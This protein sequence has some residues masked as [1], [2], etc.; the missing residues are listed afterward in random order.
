MGIIKTERLELRPLESKHAA[1]LFPIWSDEEVVKTTYIHS[2]NTIDDCINRIERVLKNSLSR[3]D[4]GPYA[5]FLENELIGIV[6]ASRDSYHEFGLA[7]HIAK[8][9]WGKGF[10]TEAAKAVVDLAFKIPEIVRISADALTTNEASSRVL[11][12]IGMKYEG[13]QRM[14][15]HRNG[16]HG[17]FNI[18]SILRSEH[19][20]V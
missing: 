7:Y 15:F 19:Q 5:I 13:C 17:D 16:I 12:K 20:T 3:R 4:I 2:I 10:A 1:Q 14:K 9:Y 6:G 11:E 18:Y 8:K